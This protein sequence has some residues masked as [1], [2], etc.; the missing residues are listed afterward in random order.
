MAA[1]LSGRGDSCHPCTRLDRLSGW[2]PTWEASTDW[3]VLELA[4]TVVLFSSIRRQ[5]APEAGR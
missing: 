1:W 2:G 5:P 4:I 3:W